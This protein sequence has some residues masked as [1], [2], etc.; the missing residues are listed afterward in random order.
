MITQDFSNRVHFFNIKV[1]NHKREVVEYRSWSGLRFELRM[2]Y[3]WYFKYQAALL[4]VKYPRFEV[5]T[6]YGHEAAQGCTLE[7][8]KQSKL[9]AKK[10]T[11]AKYK[12]LLAKAEAEWTC[13]FTI[14]DDPTYQKAVQKISRLELE[15]WKLTTQQ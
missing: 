6:F 11:I 13:M 7:Q 9:V 1:L 5:I 8:L 4:Q 12:N 14:E 2:K 10:A 3:D 15:Y